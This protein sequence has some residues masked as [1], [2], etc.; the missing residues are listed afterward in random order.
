MKV[1]FLDFN[2]SASSWIVVILGNTVS[3]QQ[4][5]SCFIKGILEAGEMRT[6]DSHARK[7]HLINRGQTVLRL[8]KK[9]PKVHYSSPEVTA[10]G[11]SDC[12]H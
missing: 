5:E 7:G 4:Q 1:G 2:P 3:I 9:H 8:R 10:I 12:H 11:T 6:P